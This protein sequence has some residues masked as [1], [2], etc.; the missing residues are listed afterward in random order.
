VYRN[1]VKLALADFT[2]TNGTTVVLANPATAG[3]VIETDS[4]YVSSVINAIP[5]TAGAVNSTYLAAGAVAQTNLAAGVAG[6]GPAFSAWQSSNTTA[7]NATWT[8]VQCNT[9]EFDTASCYDNTTNYRFT[10]NVAGYYQVNGS[11]QM[12]SITNSEVTIAIYKNGSAYKQGADYIAPNIYQLTVGSIVYLNG[13]T[14]YIEL[15]IYQSSGSSKSI[16]GNTL[17]NTYFN[18]CMVRS[19]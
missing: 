10:P 16:S 3:D 2:A 13:S 15:Y 7:N 9:K 19:A 12:V 4:F 5:A 14:D 11:A 1:G 8:K 6:N 17:T 18:A